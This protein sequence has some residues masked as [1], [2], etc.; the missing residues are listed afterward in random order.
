MERPK[1]GKI[2]L[3]KVL[4]KWGAESSAKGKEGLSKEMQESA[5]M[6]EVGQRGRNLATTGVGGTASANM[7]RRAVSLTKGPKG[8]RTK[9]RLTQ[10]REGGMLFSWPQKKK[11]EESKETVNFSLAERS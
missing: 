3:R 8:G 1:C 11:G 2:E 10:R 5:M 7:Q 6:G 9:M 4:T